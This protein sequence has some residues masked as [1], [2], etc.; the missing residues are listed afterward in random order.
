LPPARTFPSGLNATA[1]M[2]PPSLLSGSHAVL[3]RA[4]EDG[5]DANTDPGEPQAG[6]SYGGTSKFARLPL[7]LG[8]ALASF[9]ENMVVRAALGAELSDLLVAYKT[10]EWARFCG[11]VT[12]WE[13][14]EFDLAF[15]VETGNRWGLA[16]SKARPSLLDAALAAVKADGRL[17]AAGP[18]PADTPNVNI[19]ITRNPPGAPISFTANRACITHP[20]HN[21][22]K[23]ERLLEPVHYS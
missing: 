12:D 22:I 9:G 14:H 16:V 8:E 23:R 6:S 5:L 20:G 1:A 19:V 10:D 15:T 7:T 13:F 11:H 3:I 21:A 2:A 18:G 4:A 17:L